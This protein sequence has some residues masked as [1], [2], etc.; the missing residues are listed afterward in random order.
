[1]TGS[2]PT[3][4]FQAFCFRERKVI[5][6]NLG[7]KEPVLPKQIYEVEYKLLNLIK[8]QSRVVYINFLIANLCT[9]L[10][11]SG[12]TFF[13][14]EEIIGFNFTFFER[15][16][17]MVYLTTV[18]YDSWRLLHFAHKYGVIRDFPYTISESDDQI[19]CKYVIVTRLNDIN[20]IESMV[21]TTNQ[22]LKSY[23]NTSSI[24]LQNIDLLQN[25]SV[26]II[27]LRE[28][29][30]RLSHQASTVLPTIPESPPPSEIQ[31]EY[32]LPDFDS[33][34]SYESLLQD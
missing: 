13:S 2:I 5:E 22:Q 19:L 9:E 18:K 32:Y 17:D 1:M 7:L 25:Y 28:D 14:R 21:G 26:N 16:F 8:P 29:I 23:Q 34:E 11:A 10:I 4:E 12:R 27:S 31:S 33:Y 24:L 3:R 30:A 6:T 20:W 15:Y